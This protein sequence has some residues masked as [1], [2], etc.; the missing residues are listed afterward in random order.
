M[1]LHFVSAG[2]CVPNSC[3]E[4][5]V[6]VLAETG[7][8]WCFMAGRDGALGRRGR[9]GRD[10]RRCR[11]RSGVRSRSASRPASDLGLRRGPPPDLRPLQYRIAHWLLTSIEVARSKGAA[12]VDDVATKMGVPGSEV[13]RAVQH[14][15]GRLG[16]VGGRH[17]EDVVFLLRG[18]SPWFSPLL[19][20]SG[21]IDVAEACAGSGSVR[22]ARM[23][24]HYDEVEFEYATSSGVLRPLSA[25]SRAGGSNVQS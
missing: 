25:G 23:L 7:S 3:Q 10:P 12:R 21:R 1:L 16:I 8:R 11:G 17:G 22:G 20:Y 4:L 24:E 18:A 5:A 9:R 19:G 2:L 13:V 15:P 6:G 14:P